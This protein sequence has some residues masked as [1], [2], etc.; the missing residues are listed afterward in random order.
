MRVGKNIKLQGTL[1]TPGFHWIIFQKDKFGAS[2][3]LLHFTYSLI[4]Q[5]IEAGL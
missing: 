2:F 3:V 5:E 1:Y 4:R